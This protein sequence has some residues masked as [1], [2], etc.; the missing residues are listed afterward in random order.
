MSF[1]A[2]LGV[3]FLL[4]AGAM[5]ADLPKEGTWSAEFFAFGTWKG[6]PIGKTRLLGTFR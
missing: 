4:G 1:V 5:A 3:V 6:T 2:T